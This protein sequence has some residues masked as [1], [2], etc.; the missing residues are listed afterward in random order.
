MPYLQVKEKEEKVNTTIVKA[1]A[2]AMRKEDT[3]Q[4]WI[5]GAGY[6]KREETGKGQSMN[7]QI[8]L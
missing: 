8:E 7:G 1:M 3:S 6:S 4:I 5:M 2:A